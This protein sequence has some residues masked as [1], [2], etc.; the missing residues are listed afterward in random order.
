MKDAM[1]YD[2]QTQIAEMEEKIASQREEIQTKGVSHTLSSSL[3]NF[4]NLFV[5]D[6]LLRDWQRN[7]VLASEEKDALKL[8]YGKLRMCFYSFFHAISQNSFLKTI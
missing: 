2:L 5:S 8:K 3:L 1:I 4:E 7:Y 6:R